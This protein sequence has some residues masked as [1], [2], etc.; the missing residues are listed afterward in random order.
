MHF[1]LQELYDLYATSDDD[2]VTS[3]TEGRVTDEPDTSGLRVENVRPRRES[4][5][6]RMEAI[7]ASLDTM[8]IEPNNVATQSGM[9]ITPDNHSHS[10]AVF[11]YD[12]VQAPVPP[13]SP[14]QASPALRLSPR[15]ISSQGQHLPSPPMPLSLAT[16]PTSHSTSILQA[17]TGNPLG[18]DIQAIGDTPPD[19]ATF[20]GSQMEERLTHVTEQQHRTRPVDDLAVLGQR[21]TAR[22][23]R[24]AHRH[25][26]F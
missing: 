24:S 22:I 8:N 11:N 16:S 5:S 3:G 23:H 17:V 6:P 18:S 25:H 13:P 21:T 2:S 4:L 14:R 10:V 7:S 15:L 1:S 9:N 26:S 20:S 12:R 19:I